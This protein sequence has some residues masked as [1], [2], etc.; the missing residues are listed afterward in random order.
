MRGVVAPTANKSTSRHKEMNE[1]FIAR[2]F[3]YSILPLLL[4]AGHIALDRQSRTPARR[5]EIVTI[6]L[7]AISVGA[8]GLGGAFGHLFLSDL[9]AEGVGWPAGSPFQLEMGFANLVIGVLG[10][11]AIG[12]R[13]GFR[14][15]TILAT[16]ILGFGATAVHL[17]DIAATGNLAPGNTLQNLG[18][19]LD[20]ILLIT[21]TSL[22][23]RTTDPDAGS[24]AFLR[25]QQRQQPLAGMAAAGI[26]MGFGLGFAIG[27]P[28]LWTVIGAAAGVA[29]GVVVSRRHARQQSR[30]ATER[31]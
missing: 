24:S 23:G 12:R 11:L 2:T 3:A 14:T 13:D 7:L 6:Y 1:L 22:A 28:L 30:R 20:P 16:T 10:I 18:N 29:L 19:L 15:A 5:I 4:A 31:A 27:A 21:L 8:S 25:W 9:V 26:G 17:W